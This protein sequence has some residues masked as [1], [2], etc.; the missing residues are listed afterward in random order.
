MGTQYRFERVEPEYTKFWASMHVTRPS[1]ALKAVREELLPHKDRYKA[2]E[3]LTGIPYFVSMC[4]YYREALH[5]ARFDAWAHNGDPMKDRQGR[6]IRTVNVTANRPPDPNV[7]WEEG[8]HDAY[9]VCDTLGLITQ[10]S[11]ARVA[12]AAESFNGWGYRSPRINI[13]SPYL[14]GGTSVQKKGKFVADHN[15][16]AT[17]MDEQ[18]GVMAILWAIM[19]LDPEARF[20]D[21]VV[22]APA[23]TPPAGPFD[24]DDRDAD[25]APA[26]PK[27]PK[28]GDSESAQKDR[29]PKS[30]TI[31]GSVVSTITGVTSALAGFW[32][33]LDS[34]PHLI[35]FGMILVA[36]AGGAYMIVT[37]RI[38]VQKLVEH[39]SIDD[40]EDA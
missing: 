31:W 4:L 25:N 39:L 6:P 1:A 24:E 27:S 20:P 22:P 17:V 34:T 32:D 16:D 18:I 37:G 7:S 12:Y 13:P 36:L 21:A 14:W 19:E 2:Q 10:W 8:C 26:A 33:K 3:K 29:L 11:P 30:R 15:F 23:P 28:A 40:G 38:N 5:P 9:I 35:A